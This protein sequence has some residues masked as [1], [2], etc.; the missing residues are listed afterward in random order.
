VNVRLATSDPGERGL[1][2]CTFRYYDPIN[3]RWITRDPIGYDGDINLYGYV[4]GNPVMEVDPSGIK[5]PLQ[6]ELSRG[7][8]R[9]L[10]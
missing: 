10:L 5:P 3:A 7:T 8:S 6:C 1:I 2:L 4:Q 9:P